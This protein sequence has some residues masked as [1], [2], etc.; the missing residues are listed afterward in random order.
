MSQA[1][2]SLAVSLKLIIYVSMVVMQCRDS[3]VSHFS[4]YKLSPRDQIYCGNI[5]FDDAIRW[6]IDDMITSELS[7]IPTRTSIF[8]V[9]YQLVS[10]R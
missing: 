7:E 4:I 8:S 6:C 9:K 10:F 1:S 3:L 2:L 5:H